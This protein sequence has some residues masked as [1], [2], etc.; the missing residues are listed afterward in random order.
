MKKETGK[1]M[2]ELGYFA[3]LGMS[4]AISIF[5][6]LFIG[7]WLDKKFDTE[8]VLMFIGLAFGIA[9]GFSNIL[10]AGKKGRKF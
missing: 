2:R 5:I 10:R 1:T 4:V 8:P 9:A 3:S 6:G 7:L